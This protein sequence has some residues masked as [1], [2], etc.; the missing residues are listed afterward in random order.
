MKRFFVFFL[1]L[2]ACT[3][4]L[5]ENLVECAERPD[6]CIALYDPVCGYTADGSHQTYSSDCIACSEGV[7]GYIPGE[8]ATEDALPETFTECTEQPEACTKEWNPVCGLTE[9]EMQQTFGNDCVA[10]SQGAVGYTQGSC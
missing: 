3:V 5:P 2:G 4:T 1:L 9:E 8:C 10:C 7:A 6:V